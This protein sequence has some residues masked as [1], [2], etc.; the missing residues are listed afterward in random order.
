MRKRI[1]IIIFI[2]ALLYILGGCA[3]RYKMSEEFF[4]Q[5]PESINWNFFHGN[6]SATGISD[7][8]SFNGKFEILWEKKI[9]EKLTGPMTIF[10]NHLAMPLSRRKIAVYD[11]ESSAYLGKVKTRG[12]SQTGLVMVNNIGIYALAS[13]KSRVEAVDL[14]SGKR[15]W[16]K[17]LSDVT[18]GSIIVDNQLII[19]CLSGIIL[20]LNIANGEVNW[21][22][23]CK[24]RLSSPP[25][26]YAGN[27]YQAADNGSLIS[28]S[29][30]DGT[31]GFE[32]K[33]N[34]PLVGGV[35]ISKLL[36]TSEL[37][38][39]IYGIDPD[40]G[41]VV[42]NDKLNGPIWTTPAVY[43]DFVVWGTSGGELAA[44]DVEN[45]EPI[46]KNDLTDVIKASPIIINGYVICGTLSGQL[47][48]FSV[49]DGKQ[50]DNR[51]MGAAI[52]YSPVA[53]DNSLVVATQKG[54]ITCFGEN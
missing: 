3:K 47:Y 25:A 51:E 31:V 1:S 36:F 39:S 9:R 16:R 20:S 37:D 18:K 24:S 5:K 38:G 49:Y 11:L 46:W 50:I 8:I 21:E 35:A 13:P 26:Y 41:E 34:G 33:L 42:W 15:E 29:A 30:T 54:L 40:N 52:E 22:Y 7:N 23:D 45:G 32:Q 2:I 14:R 44:Y 6:Y 48:S 53:Y 12:I 4:S 28:L 19:S 43:E 27:I 10:K 17:K